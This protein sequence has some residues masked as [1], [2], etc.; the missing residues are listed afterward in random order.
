MSKKYLIEACRRCNDDQFGRE[1]INM[2]QDVP[3]WIE[4]ARCKTPRFIIDDNKDI[5]YWLI[6]PTKH[7]PRIKVGKRY[8]IPL[9][10]EWEGISPFRGLEVTVLDIFHYTKAGFDCLLELHCSDEELA[11]RYSVAIG[12][13]FTV[14]DVHDAHGDE[15]HSLGS[16]LCIHHETFCLDLIKE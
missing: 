6:D 1:Q 11:A 16:T 7:D 10:Y 2:N 13:D 15:I 9:D 8:R 3:E 5:G 4:C 14:Q 12:Q